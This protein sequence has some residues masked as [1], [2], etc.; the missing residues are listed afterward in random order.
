V[1]EKIDEN[2]NPVPSEWSSMEENFESV[3]Q[4]PKTFKFQ[5]EGIFNISTNNLCRAWGF[6]KKGEWS[7]PFKRNTFSG[8]L[9]F[10]MLSCNVIGMALSSEV[11]I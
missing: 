10:I 6:E 11:S 3:I 4:Y 1:A 9:E 7:A 2:S 5:V 8:G